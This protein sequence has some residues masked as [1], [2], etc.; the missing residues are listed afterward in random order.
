MGCQNSIGNYN[1]GGRIQ[2][3]GGAPH[4]RYKKDSVIERY[5]TFKIKGCCLIEKCERGATSKLRFEDK[6]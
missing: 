5:V 6:S 4:L 3:G 2:G 1:F